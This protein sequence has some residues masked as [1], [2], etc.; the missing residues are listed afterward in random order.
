MKLN[1]L[2]KKNPIENKLEIKN[3]AEGTIEL[4]MYGT[5][6]YSVYLNGIKYALGDVVG[7]EINV[8]I[9]S[10]GGDLFEGIAIKNFLLNPKEQ[11]FIMQALLP[12][13]LDRS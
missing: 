13:S 12:R 3:E 7:N 5:V 9:N 4:F 1:E 11:L 10:Y 8:H 6:G 2:M